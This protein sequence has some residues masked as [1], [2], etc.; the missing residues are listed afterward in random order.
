MVHNGNGQGYQVECS[1]RQNTSSKIWK[2]L[3]ERF[4]KESAPRAYE[5]KQLLSCT[6]QNGGSVSSYYTK[7]RSIWDEIRSVFPI[8]Q[9]TCGNCSC[10]IG[11]RLND[12]KEKEQLYEFLMGL[13]ADFSTIRTHVLSMK[14]T[15]T[16]GEAYH[17]ASEKEQQKSITLSKRA[18]VEP[19]TFKT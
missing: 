11:K 4:G 3:K 7:L 17:L 5:L 13:D 6:H 10:D 16:L 2:D 1:I 12:F 8:P 15:P 9:C 18:G 14:T 19:A